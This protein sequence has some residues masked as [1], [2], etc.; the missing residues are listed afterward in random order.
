M[1]ST[2]V[3]VYFPKFVLEFII[4]HV[5]AFMNKSGNQNFQLALHQFEQDRKGKAQEEIQPWIANLGNFP[6]GSVVNNSPASTGDA[7]DPCV[8]SVPGLGRSPGGGNGH[9]LHYSC[10]GNPMD[11]GAWPGCS[12]WGGKEWDTTEPK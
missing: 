9:P 7:G 11:R 10:L 3:E 6:G 12:P 1:E 5:H 2:S 8:C 4:S